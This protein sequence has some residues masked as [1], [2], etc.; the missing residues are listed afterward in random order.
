VRLA[1]PDCS[2]EMRA[3]FD[4]ELSA[5]VPNLR[6]GSGLA[7]ANG[8]LL[9]G[10]RLDAMVLE[11]LP[12]LRLVVFLSTG[13]S[14]WID[15]DAAQA[16]R[17]VVR[18]VRGYGDRSVAE[19]ALALILA[20]LRRLASMDRRLRAGHWQPLIGEELAGRRLGIVGLGGTGRALAAL[21]VALG[22]EV[23]AWNRTPLTIPGV[24]MLPLDTLLSSADIV[25]LHLLLTPQTHGLLDARRIS[26]LKRGAILINTARGSLLDEAALVAR[27]ASGEIAAGLDVFADE[28]LAADHPLLALDGVT[29]SAHAAWNTTEAARR[30]LRLGLLTLNDEAARLNT[31]DTDLRTDRLTMQSPTSFQPG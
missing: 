22:C 23:V 1:F 15:A 21:G 14:S 12:E 9:L 19:H 10:T 7:E 29:L 11:R 17:I 25:S 5:I 30:L 4:A 28:P 20:A 6:I 18:G 27:L 26:L 3:L 16:R 13:V 24:A 31:A 8:L 2:G